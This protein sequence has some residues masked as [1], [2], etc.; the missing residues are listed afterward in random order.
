[1]SPAA[2]EAAER[3]R[4]FSSG[5]WGL[6]ELA[7]QSLAGSST[8]PSELEIFKMGAI[9]GGG[10]S[11]TVAGTVHGRPCE[12]TVDTG[13]NI[14]IVRPNMLRGCESGFDSSCEQLSPNGDW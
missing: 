14:S 2:E 10:D 5:K 9:H 3:W 1:M 6:A 13:S 4:S 7:G 12:I 11:L 8:A